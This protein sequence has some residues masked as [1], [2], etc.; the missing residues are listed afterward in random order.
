MDGQSADPDIS[1]RRFKF[2][3][4]RRADAVAAEIWI[5]IEP[6]GFAESQVVHQ[7]DASHRHAVQPSD[8]Y[9]G[10]RTVDIVERFSIFGR[11]YKLSNIFPEQRF[12]TYA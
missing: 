2:S 5:N 4:Q 9:F 10:V 3:H 12:H 11:G 6:F 1:R 7:S 8:Q